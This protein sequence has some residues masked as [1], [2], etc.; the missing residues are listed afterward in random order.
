ME[1]FLGDSSKAGGG[2]LADQVTTIQGVEQCGN[3]RKQDAAM[4]VA[5]HEYAV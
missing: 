3:T 5:L 4:Y 1:T 2:P